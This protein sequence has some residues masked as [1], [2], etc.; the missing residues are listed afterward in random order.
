MCAVAVVVVA[1][2]PTKAKGKIAYRCRLCCGPRCRYRSLGCRTL[3]NDAFYGP[4]QAGCASVNLN[5]LNNSTSRVT[6]PDGSIARVDSSKE[7]TKLC[8]IEPGPWDV[9][10]NLYT[11]RE[12]TAEVRSRSQ[13]ASNCQPYSTNP[14]RKSAMSVRSCGERTATL[15]DPPIE[16]ITNVYEKGEAVSFFSAF[17]ASFGSMLLM[18][19]LV[20]SWLFRSSS[21]PLVAKIVVPALMVAL[22]CVAPYQ[23]NAMLGFPMSAS[24]ATLPARA[25]LIAFVAQDSDAR[26]DL[27]LRQGG[28]PPRARRSSAAR[29]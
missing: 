8:Y 7:T 11:D 15:S 9:G 25:E 16:P 21:A 18:G 4:R 22:A 6:I 17:A 14:I 2:A 29:L 26:V 23:V 20:A 3:R 27:W 5:C 28:A 24:L 13:Y 19:A 12:H 10:I 1:V